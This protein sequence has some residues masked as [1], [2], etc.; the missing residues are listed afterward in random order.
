MAFENVFKNLNFPPKKIIL[1][2]KFP[3][4]DFLMLKI[5]AIQRLKK[6]TF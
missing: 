2:H 1:L 3:K 5:R 4:P 6:E